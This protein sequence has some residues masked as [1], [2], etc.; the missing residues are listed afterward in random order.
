MHTIL[1][2]IQKDLVA[3]IK[4]NDRVMQTEP[5]FKEETPVV[6]TQPIKKRKKRDNQP[7]M[8]E[9][10]KSILSTFDAL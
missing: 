1:H 8:Q 10:C 9:Q 6:S 2:D 7:P 3:Y 5:V 4:T